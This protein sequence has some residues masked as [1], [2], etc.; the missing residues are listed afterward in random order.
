MQH[1]SKGFCAFETIEQGGSTFRINLRKMMRRRLGGCESCNRG[2]VPVKHEKKKCKKPLRRFDC[3]FS[4]EER[5][6]DAEEVFL[7]GIAHRISLLALQISRIENRLS[8]YET[9]SNDDLAK[10]YRLEDPP[11][12]RR[13]VITTTSVKL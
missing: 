5:S 12:N 7:D 10:P 6:C 3:F 2:M 11:L 4:E 9:R 1:S 13:R 8:D